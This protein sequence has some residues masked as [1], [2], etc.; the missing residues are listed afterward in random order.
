MIICPL[1]FG[2]DGSMKQLYAHVFSGMFFIK[3][4]TQTGCPF[5]GN[6][7]VLRYNVPIL[8]NRLL[9]ATSKFGLGKS[10]SSLQF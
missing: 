7:A 10:R 8:I 4:I 1:S 3:K 2:V 5:E 6:T 9:E